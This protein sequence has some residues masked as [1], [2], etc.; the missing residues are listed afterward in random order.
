MILLT[1]LLCK[2]VLQPE[3]ADDDGVGLEI[4]SSQ[5]LQDFSPLG[6]HSLQT[7]P[8]VEVF[9]V[10]LHVR[11]H[12][13]DFLCQDGGC[14]VPQFKRQNPYLGLHGHLLVSLWPEIAKQ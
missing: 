3:L 11:Q 5:I 1:H 2:R 8:R 7:P 6:Q 10:L 14:N 9:A 4:L 13:L 12:G